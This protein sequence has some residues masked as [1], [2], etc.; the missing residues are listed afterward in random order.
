MTMRERE[1]TFEGE[2]GARLHAR[3]WWPDA[4]PHSIAVLTHGLAEHCG[5]YGELVGHLTDAGYAVYA[6]DHRGHGRSSGGR[7]NID[8]FEHVL[9]DVDRLFA[10]ARTDWPG[11]PATL[12]GH[13]M[14]GAIAFAYARRHQAALHGL[15]LSAPLLGMN[16]NVPKV[17]ELVARLLSRLAPGL[18]VL[19]LPADTISRDPAVVRAYQQD[20]L[21]HSGAIP[22]RTL[23]ELVDAVQ[24]FPSLAPGLQLPV[25][26]LHGTGDQLVPPAFT[27]PVVERFGS[28]DRTVRVYD[29]LYHEVFNEPERARV[30]ADLLA[31][32][33][34]RRTQAPRAA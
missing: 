17:Q 34:E 30:Y 16:P 26:V 24:T 19:K 25:L 7:A 6:L 10:Q 3:H 22:A 15:V 32:L 5:R 29:G 21:V 9:A 11:R 31:W 18:G 23:V 8:R 28:A 14:G 33:A 20:P 27:M 12:I 4:E 13:S 1:W 2:A